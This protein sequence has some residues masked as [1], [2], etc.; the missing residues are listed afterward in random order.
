MDGESKNIG[1]IA[2]FLG[3]SGFVFPQ[4]SLHTTYRQDKGQRL[5]LVPLFLASNLSA[6]RDLACC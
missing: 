1:S 4:V 3:F 2:H 5:Y 6:H